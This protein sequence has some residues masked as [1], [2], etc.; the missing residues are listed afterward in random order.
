MPDYL[1][2]M[3]QAIERIG[4]YVA[5]LDEAGFLASEMTQDAVIRNIEIIGEA[6]RNIQTVAP[7]FA[8]AH[9][10][11]P[12]LVMYTMRNRVSYGYDQVDLEVVWQT[13]KADLPRLYLQ[14]EALAR[15]GDFEKGVEGYPSTDSPGSK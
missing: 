15:A 7:A 13:V 10:D 4:R 9:A 5:D 12:W 6:A 2:H 3:L 14:I 1:A 8:Q 11:V